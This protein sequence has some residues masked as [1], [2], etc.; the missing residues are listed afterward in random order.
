MNRWALM[1]GAVCANVVEQDSA[2]QIGGEWVECTGLAVGPGSRLVGGEWLPEPPA[3]SSSVSM[4]QA[5]LALHAAGKLATVDA[6]INALS[7]PDKTLALIEWNSASTVDRNHPTVS[8]ISAAAG[9]SSAEIDS[10]FAA[11]AQIT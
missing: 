11:A 4:R 3:M 10:L 2:P 5:K 9:M 1:Q 6:A 8:L 7:E